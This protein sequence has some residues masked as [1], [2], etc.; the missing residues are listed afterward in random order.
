MK[1]KVGV[2][3]I[4]DGRKYIHEDLLATNERYQN[5]LVKTLEATGEVEVVAGKEIIWTSKIA[6][7]EAHGF[8]EKGLS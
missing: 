5:R 3:T 7:R 1:R 6:Q 4:S 2:L 8:P